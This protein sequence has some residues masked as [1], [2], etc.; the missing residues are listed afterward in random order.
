MVE[1]LKNVALVLRQ[2]STAASNL[3]SE[4]LLGVQGAPPLGPPEG[5]PEAMRHSMRD[6]TLGMGKPQNIL[7]VVL[8]D[9]LPF[10]FEPGGED[11]RGFQEFAVQGFG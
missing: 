7:H 9:A 2:V 1:Y 8:A 4:G 6:A 11:V 3:L 10:L 5:P